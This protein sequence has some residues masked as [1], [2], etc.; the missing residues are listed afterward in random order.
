MKILI[1]MSTEQYNDF[2]TKCRDTWLLEAA[3]LKKGVPI[4]HKSEGAQQQRIAV[5][6]E[7]HQAHNLLLIAR[8][9]NLPVA[10]DIRK[11]LGSSNQ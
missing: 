2:L 6:C 9:L 1:E 8:S 11:A 7:G 10:D 3:I 5:L 4:L